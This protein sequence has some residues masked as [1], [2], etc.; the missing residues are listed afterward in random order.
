M[1]KRQTFKN[2]IIEFFDNYVD[3]YYTSRSEKLIPFN[4]E[5]AIHE[6][7]ATAGLAAELVFV[8]YEKQMCRMKKYKPITIIN[9]EIIMKCLDLI[10]KFHSLGYYHGD[11]RLANILQKENGDV[12]FIDFEYAKKIE[13]NPWNDLQNYVNR[14]YD[15]KKFYY[16]FY[17]HGYSDIEWLEKYYLQ[18]KYLPCDFFQSYELLRPQSPNTYI[19]YTN[20]K[21]LTHLAKRGEFPN[22]EKIKL[23]QILRLDNYIWEEETN[24]NSHAELICWLRDNIEEITNLTL[25]SLIQQCI[26][27]ERPDLVK[28]LEK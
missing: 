22:F 18:N 25:H 13:K 1:I 2:C 7:A 9:K 26:L 4:E 21:K 28:L 6:L 12:L 10:T 23:D 8:D 27:A 20:V 3:K 14:K 17:D 16:F 5:M 11:V 15:Y 24:R 19:Y